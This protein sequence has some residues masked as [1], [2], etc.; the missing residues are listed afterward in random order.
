[1]PQTAHERRQD[2]AYVQHSLRMVGDFERESVANPQVA[3]KKPVH[4]D[5]YAITDKFKLK[6]IGR[7]KIVKMRWGHTYWVSGSVKVPVHRHA[8][9]WVLSHHASK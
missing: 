9:Q 4:A 6:K 5:V 2:K 7:G 3:R 8:N 1:M